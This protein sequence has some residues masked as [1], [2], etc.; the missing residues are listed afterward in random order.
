MIRKE[1]A[2]QYHTQERPGKIEVKSTKACITQRDLAMAYTPGLPNLAGKSI[3][4]RTGFLT[5]QPK[6]TSLP[7]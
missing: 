5:I 2:L 7:W 3:G 1:D 6:E 4:M